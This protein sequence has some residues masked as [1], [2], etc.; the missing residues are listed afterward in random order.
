MIKSL[1]LSMLY[2]CTCIINV[3]RLCLL[4]AIVLNSTMNAS[5]LKSFHEMFFVYSR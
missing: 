2:E 1:K 5:V 3:R 4:T